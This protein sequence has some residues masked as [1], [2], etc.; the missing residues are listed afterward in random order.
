MK[1]VGFSIH[2]YTFER[3]V[4]GLKEILFKD[5]RRQWGG[6]HER[7]RYVPVHDCTCKA[8]RLNYVIARQ[9]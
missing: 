2:C 5:M 7:V 9:R 4:C 8:S 1:G 6:L 3:G